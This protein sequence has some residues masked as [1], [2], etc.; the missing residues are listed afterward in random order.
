MATANT[1]FIRIDSIEKDEWESVVNNALPD[2]SEYDDGSTLVV[3]DGQWEVRGDVILPDPYDL[4]DGLTIVTD[5]GEWTT[6][7]YSGGSSGTQLYY[8]QMTNAEAVTINANSTGLVSVSYPN[9]YV[10]QNRQVIIIGF[11]YM[12]MTALQPISQ[13]SLLS[14]SA[15]AYDEGIGGSV[16]VRNNTN[17]SITIDAETFYV[18]CALDTEPIST[19]PI[20]VQA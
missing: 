3:Y 18:Y 11:E 17:S 9:H 6:A 8:F 20:E 7:P 15:E 16:Y 12:G 10:E 4:D 5:G 14:Y 13:P 1:E 2:P 19:E